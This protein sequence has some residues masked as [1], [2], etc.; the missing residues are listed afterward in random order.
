MLFQSATLPSPWSPV[1]TSVRQPALLLPGQRHYLLYLL[2]GFRSLL[3]W[4]PLPFSTYIPLYYSWLCSLFSKHSPQ[5][6]Y[7]LS[8]STNPVTWSAVSK[9]QAPDQ[10]HLNHQGGLLK[11]KILSPA[12]HYR[13]WISRRWS[14]EYSIKLLR[15]FRD[16]QMRRALLCALPN[17]SLQPLY[18]S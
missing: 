3:C 1:L 14:Q 4:L 6:T 7:T 8:T 13:I 18:L 11:T 9:Q 17:L 2:Q 10:L 15:G 12:P 5:R 16:S